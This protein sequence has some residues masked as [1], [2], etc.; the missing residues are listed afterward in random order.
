[1]TLLKISL[2]TLLVLSLNAC[3]LTERAPMGTLSPGAHAQEIR[4]DQTTNL[5]QV[6]TASVT[7]Y[8]NP[9]NAAEL[10]QKKADAVGAHYYFVSNV[11]PT[12]V[13]NQW[14]SQA[15]LYR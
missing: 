15:I 6:G 11:E 12:Q 1:M 2:S 9:M 10:I 4:R 7:V 8:G 13:P 3:S 14:I 5:T